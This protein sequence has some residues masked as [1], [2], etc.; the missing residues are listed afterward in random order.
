MQGMIFA[1]TMTFSDSNAFFIDGMDHQKL[2][3][4]KEPQN[5]RE[6]EKGTDRI[7]GDV[8]HFDSPEAT[9]GGWSFMGDF[10]HFI[11]KSKAEAMG[12][13]A[14]R[15]MQYHLLEKDSECILL[16]H[17]YFLEEKTP[18]DRDPK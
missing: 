18:S 10:K 8:L 16:I 13:V 1:E 17:P 5:Q 6:K 3:W 12:K 2:P 7:E 15:T 14:T 9:V 11:F 4:K